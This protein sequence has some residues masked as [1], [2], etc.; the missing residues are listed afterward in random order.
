MKS[1]NPG[2]LSSPAWPHL[3]LVVYC[4]RRRRVNSPLM[5]PFL[6]TIF[7]FFARLDIEVFG[8]TRSHLSEKELLDLLVRRLVHA[9]GTHDSVPASS[10]DRVP[11]F[12]KRMRYIIDHG[13]GEAPYE[14]WQKEVRV[15]VHSIWSVVV[16]DFSCSFRY[17]PVRL[18]VSLS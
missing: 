7:L 1:L 8:F 2:R 17:T 13:E 12:M 15:C 14:H 5:R 18:P 6:L 9:E 4:Q 3:I 11:E 10:H 16:A